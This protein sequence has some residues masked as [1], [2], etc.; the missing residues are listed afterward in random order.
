M[1]EGRGIE[2]EPYRMISKKEIRAG[3]KVMAKGRTK[4]ALKTR[5]RLLGG[6]IIVALCPVSIGATKLLGTPHDVYG[7]ICAWVI[8]AGVLSLGV[9]IGLLVTGGES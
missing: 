7:V 5:Y 6:A 8:G 1:R 9:G 3:K 4:M 2:M